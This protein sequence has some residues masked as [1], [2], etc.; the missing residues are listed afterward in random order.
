M[1]STS[2]RARRPGRP[3]RISGRLGLDAAC[4]LTDRDRRILRLLRDHRVLATSQIT[5]MFFT[6]RNTCQ[7]RLARLYRLRLVDRFRLPFPVDPHTPVL[8]ATG[9][10]RLTEYG[11]VLDRVGAQVLAVERDENTDV[12]LDRVRWDT[13]Q[14]LTIAGSPRLA[15]TLGTNQFF[16]SLIGAARHLPSAGLV[17]WW[18]EGYCRQ[19]LDG[20]VNPDGIGVWHQDGRRLTFALEYD[21]GSETLGRLGRKGFDYADLET[22]SG[23]PFTVLVVLPGPRREIGARAALGRHGLAVATASQP[24]TDNPAA[25]IWAPLAANPERARVRLIDLASWPRPTP[26]QQ[27]LDAHPQRAANGRT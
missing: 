5:V 21:R 13:G 18:G 23:W 15:H 22:V 17:S 11:Y 12:D 19:L 2:T 27:R 1:T 6:D 16:V 24:L 25:A 9:Y 3:T 20:I 14:S 26:S 7:H 10:V 4:S 8:T